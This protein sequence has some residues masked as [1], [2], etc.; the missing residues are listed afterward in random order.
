MDHTSLV[1]SH[2]PVEIPLS[3]IL[4]LSLEVL[5][6]SWQFAPCW[7]SAPKTHQLEADGGGGI[8]LNE[9]SVVGS[10]VN[11][12]VIGLNAGAAGFRLHSAPSG[13]FSGG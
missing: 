1:A 5:L 3:D 2:M 9:N 8:F 10:L 4:P 7:N 11:L 6:S 13:L 12:S